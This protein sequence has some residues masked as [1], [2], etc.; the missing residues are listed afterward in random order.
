[1]PQ[2]QHGTSCRC[3]G[4]GRDPPFEALLKGVSDGTRTHDRLDHNQELYQLSYAHRGA[5]NLAVDGARDEALRRWLA[6]PAAHQRE[7]EM[8]LQ[9]PLPDDAV[10]VIRFADLTEDLRAQLEGDESDPFGAAALPFRLSWR[11]KDQHV[12][13]RNAAGRLVASAGIVV[14]EVVGGDQAAIEVVGIGGVIVNAASRGQGLGKRV[15]EEVVELAR[16][17]G[18]DIAMLFCHPDRAD[19]YRRHGFTEVPGPVVVEGPD[20]P[21]TMP[22]VTMWRPLREGAA[23]PAGP[24]RVSGL[25]F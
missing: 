10:E 6:L 12:G 3:A 8:T 19:L 18:P 5:L 22:M 23:L 15:I 25:P 1:M 7:A 17:A 13:L 4:G 20:G 2:A 11:G 9:E 14:A 21:V 16:N 24:V